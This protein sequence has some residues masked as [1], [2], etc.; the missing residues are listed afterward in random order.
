MGIL[1]DGGDYNSLAYTAE[2]IS[3]VQLQIQYSYTEKDK[4]V[5]LFYFVVCF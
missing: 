3:E 1:G 5:N 4:K 2:P